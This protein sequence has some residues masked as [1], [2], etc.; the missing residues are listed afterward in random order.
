MRL[1]GEEGAECFVHEG[2]L[3]RSILPMEETVGLQFALEGYC[4]VA[5]Y[6]A[7]SKCAYGGNCVAAMCP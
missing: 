4:R 3:V 5:M 6:T 2:R 7:E 1:G